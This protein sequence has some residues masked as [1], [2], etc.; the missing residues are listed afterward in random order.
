[1]ASFQLSPTAKTYFGMLDQK[2]KTGKFKRQLQ[3]YWLC[4]QLGLVK[5]ETA[6]PGASEVYDRFPEPIK[7]S[8][9]LIR[10][11]VFWR[12]L[13]ME[14]FVPEDSEETM[15]AL[16]T[17]FSDEEPSKISTEGMKFMDGLAAA[18][19]N[20]IQQ[21]IPLDETNCLATFLI[22]YTELLEEI[23]PTIST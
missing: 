23:D 6:S 1:M 20:I 22:Q 5:E 3:F 12:Y 8:E 9:E 18:G 11:I 17:F 16:R 19:F 10:G 13:K 4:C 7:S 2:S 21:K 14:G 15:T